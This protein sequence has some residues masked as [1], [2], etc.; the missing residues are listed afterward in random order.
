MGSCALGCSE[1]EN[2]NRILISCLNTPVVWF[3]CHFIILLVDNSQGFPDVA[4]EYFVIHVLTK[5][6]MTSSKNKLSRLF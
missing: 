5:I 1:Y 3:S 6:K 2:M 4:Q